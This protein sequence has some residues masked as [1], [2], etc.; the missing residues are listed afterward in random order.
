MSR[1]IFGFCHLRIKSA[2]FWMD[3]TFKDLP[4]FVRVVFSW[5]ECE[6]G[7]WFI[8]YLASCL[9]ISTERLASWQKYFV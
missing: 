7:H 3:V 1:K 9:N 4:A 5:R 2:L 6:G 8:S